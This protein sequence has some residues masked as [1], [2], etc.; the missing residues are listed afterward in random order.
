MCLVLASCGGGGSSS[1][2]SKTTTTPPT[3]T[4]NPTREAAFLAALA[5]NRARIDAALSDP[6]APITDQVLL[7]QA[8]GWCA[9]LQA[10]QTTWKELRDNAAEQGQG[11]DT[12]WTYDVKLVMSA[13][14]AHLC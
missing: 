7:G 2:K 8:Y 4:T 14:K 10:H 11:A 6:N 5:K 9:A 1:A 3:V 13:A 12:E